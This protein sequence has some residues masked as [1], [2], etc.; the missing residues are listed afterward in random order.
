MGIVVIMRTV[1]VVGE[2]SV[3]TR[4]TSRPAPPRPL[5]TSDAGKGLNGSRPHATPVR[6]RGRWALHSSGFSAV[7]GGKCLRW[8]RPPAF[9]TEGTLGVQRAV[10]YLKGT[11][12]LPYQGTPESLLKRTLPKMARAG[13]FK[14]IRPAPDNLLHLRPHLG[15]E[16][17]RSTGILGA[18]VFREVRRAQ[19]SAARLRLRLPRGR[20]G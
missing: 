5:L 7:A 19:N 13:H 1:A 15:W 12:V 20:R 10:L 4:D 6:M 16:V 11:D 2:W 8:T 17:A 9:Y 18:V 3:P 14:M